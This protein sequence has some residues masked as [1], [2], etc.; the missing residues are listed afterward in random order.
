MYQFIKS[1]VTG[2]VGTITL[3]RPEA[4]N[5]FR[6]ESYGEIRHAVEMFSQDPDIGAIVITGEGKHFSAGGDIARFKTLIENGEYL[7][8]ENIYYAGEMTKAIRR[9][10]KPVIAMI[11][12]VATGAGLSLCLACDFRVVDNTSRLIMGFIKLGLPGDT[13]SIYLLARLIGVEKASKMM[14][15]GE[16]ATGETAVEMGLATLFAQEGELSEVAY[17]FADTLSNM[18]S[19]AI[20][21]QKKLLAD[22]F[23]KDLEQYY[24]DEAGSM[25][26]SA[27]EPDFAEAVYAFLE[28]RAP[29]YN[30]EN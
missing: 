19:K 23:Y 5:A 10:P 2:R 29:Q 26:A 17:A 27:R 13:G 11:N 25:A 24:Q 30:K 9:S 8:A 21:R 6:Y 3:N 7:D 4:S 1:S 22:Y 12:G 20:A 15:T 16:T 28:R 14:M 18:P